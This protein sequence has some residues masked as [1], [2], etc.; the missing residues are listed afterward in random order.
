MKHTRLWASFLICV[1]ALVLSIAVIPAFTIGAS[2]AVSDTATEYGTVPAANAGNTFV[3]F[4]GERNFLSGADTWAAASASA[5]AWLDANPGKTVNVLLQKDHTVTKTVGAN[6][7]LGH[8]NGTVNIDLDG[9]TLIADANMLYAGINTTYTGDFLTNVTVKDGTLLNGKGLAFTAYNKPGVAKRIDYLFD[10]ITF[11]F[12]SSSILSNMDILFFFWKTD[13]NGTGV[14]DMNLTFESCT[15]DASSWPTSGTDAKGDFS[16]KA[17]N[18]NYHQADADILVDFSFKGGEIVTDGIARVNVNKLASSDSIR[19][20]P[21]NEGNYVT[22]R[23]L[24]GSVPT[25]SVP[26]DKGTLSFTKLIT[27]A[28]DVNTYALP[29]PTENAV[30]T[31]YGTIPAGNEAAVFAVFQNKNFLGGYATWKTVNNAVKAALDTDATNPVE[32]LLLSS[33]QSTTGIDGT[34]WLGHMNGKVIYDLGGNT[35]IADAVLFN[36][37]LYSSSTEEIP[38]STAI[39]VKNGTLLQGKNYI[40]SSSNGRNATKTETYTFTNVTFGFN[41]VTAAY[42]R[43][44]MIRAQGDTNSDNVGVI[45]LGLT[46]IDCTFDVS[47]FPTDKDYAGNDCS[48]KT[49]S[50]FFSNKA[51]ASADVKASVNV[52]GGA[53][54]VGSSNKIMITNGNI[55]PTTM[56]YPNDG[57]D[58]AT[59]SVLD[60]QVPAWTVPTEEG[61]LGFTKLVTDG[62][63]RDVYTLPILTNRPI[64]TPYGTIPA[65]YET[66]VFAVFRNGSFLT[67]SDSWNAANQAARE[68]L[69]SDS[70]AAVTVLVRQNAVSDSVSVANRLTRMNGTVVYDLG[71]Y[72]ISANKT[73]LETG[74]DAN[75]DG[76]C[77][78]NIVVK[79]GT[80]LANA[81]H[82]LATENTSSYAE[83]MTITFENVT[84]GNATSVASSR[85]YL[86]RNWGGSAALDLKLIFTDC[87]IDTTGWNDA[88]SGY[89]YNLFHDNKETV[90]NVTVTGGQIITDEPQHLKLHSS[91]NILFVKDASGNYTTM[92]VANGIVPS[93]SVNTDTV[94]SS[95]TKLVSDGAERDV[96]A[97]D[98]VALSTKYGNIPHASAGN[99]FAI[100]QNGAF[101]AGVDAWKDVNTKVLA[102]LTQD[103]D[104]PVQVLVREDYT[105]TATSNNSEWCGYFNGEVLFDLDGH[106]MIADANIFNAGINTDYSGNFE[107]NVT[108]KNG[109]LLNGK[110]LIF[111]LYNKPGVDKTVNF[112]F[113]DCTF[114]F[115]AATIQSNR[116]IF[117]FCWKTNDNG[118]GVLDLNVSLDNCTLD[119]RG[120]KDSF[121]KLATFFHHQ[122][123]A[124]I[125]AGFEIFG[126]EIITDSLQ[127]LCVYNFPTP[128]YASI[129]F[130][131]D[132][133]G[134]YATL[135]VLNGATPNVWVPTDTGEADFSKLSVD[136]ADRDV[137]ALQTYEQISTEYLLY[138]EYKGERLYKGPFY[139]PTGASYNAV[140]LDA[141]AYADMLLTEQTN[142]IRLSE[143]AGLRF[144]TRIDKALLDE[145]FALVAEGALDSVEFGTLI[146]PE[147][148]VASELTMEAMAA[149]GKAYLRIK[150]DYNKYFAYD[151]DPSTT[152]F[153]GAIVNLYESNVDRTFLGRGYVKITPKSG[154]AIILYSDFTQ[155]AD[156][157]SKASLILEDA[158][159]VA[160]LSA[161]H[162]AILEK[163]AAGELPP[164][165]E[166]TEDNRKLHGLNVL[167]I[168]DSLFYGD[169]LERYQQWIALLARECNWNLTNLG[170][171]GWTLAHLEGRNNMSMS[172]Q[173]LNNANYTYGSTSFY[174]MGNTAGKTAEDVDLIFLEGGFNDWGHNV[175]LG[176][177]TSTDETTMLGAMNVI[178]EK[179]KEVYPNATIVLITSWHLDGSKTLNGETVYRLDYTAEGM[180]SVYETNYRYD[181]RVRLIDAGDPALTDIHMYDVDW[182]T[183]YSNKPSD[184]CHLN[185]KGMEIMAAHMLPLLKETLLSPVEQ[186]EEETE[187][188]PVPEAPY[189]RAEDCIAANTGNTYVLTGDDQP[190]F[191]GRWF[192]K[193]YDGVPH[194]VTLNTGSVVYFMVNGAQ[195][196]NLDFTVTTV[197]DV[198]LPYFSYSIDGSTPVRQLITDGV[199][200]LPDMGYHIVRIITDGLTEGVGKWDYERGFALKSITVSEGGEMIGVKPADKTIFFFGDSITEG[201][202]SLSAGYKSENNSVTAAYSW[203]TAE[204]LHSVPYIVGYGASGIVKPGSFNNME[205]AVQYY[206]NNRPVNDGVQPDV[207]VINHGHN[208]STADTAEFKETLLRTIALL[209]ELYPNAEIVYVIPLNQAK[210]V[211]IKSCLYSLY[212]EQIHVVESANWAIDKTDSAHPSLEGA[213]TVAENLSKKLVEIF[214]KEF[215]G[216]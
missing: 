5:R 85:G 120:W 106:T 111:S 175:P 36:S 7:W 109:T 124:D 47:A 68:A 172:Y 82:I 138:V 125:Q 153:V 101:F 178:I 163:F 108:V 28:M 216:L 4:D 102:A 115:N 182:R 95:F 155:A 8:M 88:Y 14:M 16:K 60:G 201:V 213:T 48:A 78:P 49:P 211:A 159:Y 156:V 162:K 212:D 198:D 98:P 81:A 55:L 129:T 187:P 113:E 161:A 154:N 70:T 54:I 97:L 64:E 11:G 29:V 94:Y 200:A 83:E 181:E 157:Q 191:M 57:G 152:H 117:F 19:F 130:Q 169:D 135:S 22:L 110:G 77:N 31:D 59:L 84:L 202:A 90:M 150:A 183:V 21:D 166:G 6:D 40:F 206:S 112:T 9:H 89:G 50:V 35:L 146:A 53:F 160:T 67:A 121:N 194:M 27:V 116:D 63:D 214:G 33:L 195:S 149:A 86:F 188:A 38:A 75:Y 174:N 173:L 107:T 93:H 58:Y 204:M 74:F 105:V 184:A 56:F 215:F 145:L 137:Y 193:E 205:N 207:I 10:N 39:E 32:V 208:D 141:E 61:T 199:V 52:Y 2:A 127:Y 92:S 122:G 190:Y 44:I 71:G 140:Y 142:S 17:P 72:T 165:A 20:L 151:E 180:K 189:L 139:I 3:L 196:V 136:G 143:N 15:F 134:N 34:S 133:E 46:F 66:A 148:Y 87:T 177:P 131:K 147:D 26:T 176:T 51:V 103:S 76:S 96:Y 100:F 13:G 179:L 168:G 158:A 91:E 209:R 45:D 41:A 186:P 167:A 43:D 164:A 170:K 23:V 37:G 104:S 65:E 69:A 80:L 42:N 30:V 210:S 79:N 1:L 99:A 197:N 62:A 12:N 132:A 185:A 126:G 192:E 119:A 144:A 18:L 73:I 128:A 171:G 118:T 24:N 114:G 25:L 123:D 203:L